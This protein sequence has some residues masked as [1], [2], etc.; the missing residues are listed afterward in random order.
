MTLNFFRNWIGRAKGY[1]GCYHCGDTWNWKAK[2]F[3]PYRDGAQ[4][5]PLC[6]ECFEKLDAKTIIDYC[7]EL[8][9]DWK[10]DRKIHGDMLDGRLLDFDEKKAIKAIKVFVERVKRAPAPLPA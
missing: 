6:R 3:I 7:M 8:M 1:S 4:M 9:E 2:Y 10:R 5:F